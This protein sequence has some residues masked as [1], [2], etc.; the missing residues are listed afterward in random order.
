MSARPTGACALVTGG[1]RGIGAAISRALAATGWSVAVNYRSDAA[2]AARTVSSI[3]DAGGRA[4]A[5]AGDVTQ[6]DTATALVQSATDE[7]GPVLAWS[8]TPACAPTTW[9]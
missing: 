4:I 1:S 3:E 9:R 8:T 2:A 7:L 5:L 6:A